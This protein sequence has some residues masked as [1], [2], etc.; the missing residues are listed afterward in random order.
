MSVIVIG[1]GPAGMTAAIT[2]AKL[3]KNVILIEK[4]EKTGKKLYITGKGRCNIIN[5][6]DSNGFLNNIIGNPKFLTSAI[7]KFSP[8]DAK[9]FLTEELGLKIKTERGNR[10][11]PASDKSSDVIAAF[12]RALKRLGVTVKLC[13]KVSDIIIE[14]NTAVA[15]ITDKGNYPCDSVVIATGG[16]SYPATGSDGDGYLFAKKMGHKIVTPKPSLVKLKIKGVFDANN[17]LIATDSLPYPE[18][19]SLKNVSFCLKTVNG[20]IVHCGDI[21]ELL[22]T[23]D[24]LSGPLALTASAYIS[25]SEE[26]EFIAFIDLKPGI[27]IETLDKKLIREFSENANKIFKNYLIGLLPK[28]IIPFI[29]MLSGIKPE[30]EVNKIT[31]KERSALASILKAIKFKICGT[32]GFDE[33][34]ITS[35][36]ISVKELR[37]SDM[38]SKLVDNVRFAGEVID[39][40][41]L[42]GGFNIQI[43]L[44]TGVAAGKNL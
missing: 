24:G 7:N 8:N 29:I 12:N 19:L 44:S 15:V 42:T 6:T 38:S 13:E 14:N 23:R 17:T 40:D 31:R 27:D 20:K 34:V 16:L 30:T 39:V 43:A 18:G 1:A 36:G 3:G 2:A 11:F 22:F 37:P 9:L 33:A 10:V 32:G 35:G 41:G 5:D 28:S 25:K 4:N 21:G 26:K